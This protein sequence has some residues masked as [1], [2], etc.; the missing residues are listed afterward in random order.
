[1]PPIQT[2]SLSYNY[3]VV[4]EILAP[5]QVA[6]LGSGAVLV[7]RKWTRPAYRFRIHALQITKAEMEA[8]Y[9]FVTYHQGDIAFWFDGNEW[10]N[11]ASAI[12]VGF[13]NNSQ[14]DFFLPNRNVTI[15][16]L[17]M[18]VSDVPTNVENV[19]YDSGRVRFATAPG[20]DARITAVYNCRYKCAFWVDDEAMLSFENFTLQLHNVEGIVLREIVP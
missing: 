4:R 12:L 18:Y 20:T 11:V 1:M 15:G 16:T 5:R 19:N 8:F 2:L 9:G 14:R 7:R 3:S 6:S 17:Q 10:G 13:G